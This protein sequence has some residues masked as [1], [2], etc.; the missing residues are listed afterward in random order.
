MKNNRKRQPRGRQRPI[1]N[2]GFFDEDQK[3]Q[4]AERNR[5][6]K[7]QKQQGS[8]E[9]T[10]G[11]NIT[12]AKEFEALTKR[13]AEFMKAYRGGSNIF[14]YGSAGTGKTYLALYAALE[15]LKKKEVKR[16]IIVRSAVPVRDQGFLPGTIEEKEAPLKAAYRTIVNDICGC[17]TAFDDLSKKRIIQF[18]S[19]SYLRSVTL[20]DA[21]IILDEVQNFSLEEGVTALTRVGLRSRVVVCG[22]GKQDDLHYKKNDVSG[23]DKILAITKRMGGEYFSHIQFNRDDIVRSG[24]VKAVIIACEDLKI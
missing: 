19:T 14:A 2:D 8:Q 15:S 9:R 11:V 7:D 5:N 4:R 17:G 16:I 6:K 12:I 21:A 24:F 13:Q 18:V 20:D 22:D 10:V 1:F 3:A 23:F